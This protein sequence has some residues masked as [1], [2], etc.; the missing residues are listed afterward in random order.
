MLKDKT[1]F[2]RLTN[3]RMVSARPMTVEEKELFV[4]NLGFDRKKVL[5]ACLFSLLTT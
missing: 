1:M 5:F 4:K 2:R 3:A